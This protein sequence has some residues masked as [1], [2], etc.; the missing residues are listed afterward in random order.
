DG[1]R[2]TANTEPMT[3]EIAL[4]LGRAAAFVFKTDDKRRHRIVIGK[5]TRLSGYMLESA[6][7]SG[8]CS[9]GVDVILVGPLPTPGIAF[10][11]RSLRADAGVVISAS[12]NTYE[13]NGIKFFSNEGFKLPASLERRMEEMIA[14]GEIDHIR[15]TATDVGKAFRDDDAIGRYVE[16]IKNS[17]PKGMTLDGIRIALDCA[18][19]AAYKVAP[20][21]LRELGAEVIVY[22]DHPDGTNINCGCGSLHP[23]V[24]RKA[25]IDHR[26]DVGI[27]LDGD[28]DRVILADNEAQEVDGDHI[29]AICAIDMIRQKKLKDNAIVATI[30][31]NMGLDLAIQKAGGAIYKA[32]VGDR[33]VIEEMIKRDLYIGG[34]QSGHCIFREY[35]TTG[36]GMITALQVLQIMKRTGKPLSQLAKCMETMPQVL[37]NVRVKTKQPFDEIDDIKT[38]M[39]RIHR[40]LDGKGRL[41]LRYSGT[42][43]IARVMIEGPDIDTINGLAESMAVVIRNKLA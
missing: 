5:D 1:V 16:F 39:T 14:S 33:Y 11:T 41:L 15:P 27:S 4:K 31:S 32:D 19:G 21:V 10:I 18:N 26:V 7:V 22:N 3:A 34:E 23:Q 42:E 30:M 40:K 43:N 36:D 28:A 12:H 6:L 20:K 2:G 38:E 37:L 24:I 25:V 17:F 29:L 13:D 35:T 8:I 9:M